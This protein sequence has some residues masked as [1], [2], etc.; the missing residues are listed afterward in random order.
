MGETMKISTF[1]NRWATLVF[2]R[3][4]GMPLRWKLLIP[5]MGLM[6]ASL[7]GLS[8]LANH[9]SRQALQRQIEAQLAEDAA[10]SARQ[11]S[12]AF[13]NQRM[14]LAS[15]AKN[16]LYGPVA[17]G[18]VHPAYVQERLAE[19]ADAFGFDFLG[20]LNAEGRLV[21]GS[22]GEEGAD[23]G[24]SDRDYFHSAMEGKPAISPAIQSRRTGAPVVVLAHPLRHADERPAGV[25]CGVLNL[26][27]LLEL[28]DIRKT[29]ESEMGKADSQSALG[30]F[31][32]ANAE[33]TMI[34]HPDP[35]KPFHLNCADFGFFRQM[36]RE[37]KGYLHYAFEGIEKF[38]GFAQVAETGWYLV[39]TAD[40]HKLF[41][42][43][44]RLRRNG[45]ILT[46]CAL[47]SCLFL[48]T[49]VVLGLTRPLLSTGRELDA[50]SGQV[51]AASEQIASAHQ[52][53]SQGAADQSG[54]VQEMVGAVERIT[55]GSGENADL[56][57]EI[58]RMISQEAKESF[59]EI[60]RRVADTGQAVS[61]AL[62]ISRDASAVIQMI[63]DISFQS[64]LLSLNA[65]VEAARVG[66]A[67]GGFAVVAAEMK[68]LAG[69][70][71]EA[72]KRTGELLQEGAGRIETVT[73]HHQRLREALDGNRAIA[74]KV[75]EAA[76]RM[77]G[78]VKEEAE[79][80]RR[81]QASMERIDQVISQNAA[82]AEESASASEEMSAQAG[83]LR[84]ISAAIDELISGRRMNSSAESRPTAPPRGRL[85]S[86]HTRPAVLIPASTRSAAA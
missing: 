74:G 47:G 8:T 70:T 44:Y 16:N 82:F 29:A 26:S 61:D 48:M 36:K 24:L 9:Q 27:D 13:Q 64:R 43:I 75:L 76:E 22:D 83:Q 11:L 80:L 18:D 68:N 28:A 35:E 78:A 25:L 54:A 53:L 77:A 23:L 65:A 86:A 5:V 51:A 42:P 73:T 67:G 4:K 39:Y 30:Y 7:L 21:V 71:A 60:Q 2:N 85:R 63:E 41:Q 1:E 79:A 52:S 20:I 62:A 84:A 69:Q 58:N 15:W 72:A 3:L 45:W 56:A 37:G 14:N 59:E 33:G 49:L 55:E 19:S 66:E 12:R 6:A 50:M 81:I 32:M 57:A 46:A 10:A 38:A 40:D 34:H 17:A 31:Y